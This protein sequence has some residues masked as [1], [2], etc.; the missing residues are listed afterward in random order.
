MLNVALSVEFKIRI[1]ERHHCSHSGIFLNFEQIQLK[2]LSLYRALIPSLIKD[3]SSIGVVMK[4]LLLKFCNIDRKRLVLE[5]FLIKL[6]GFWPAT[7]Y[8][9]RLQH[10]CFFQE[11]CEIITNTY[12]GQ[13]LWTAASKRSKL[14]HKRNS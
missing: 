7:L 10:R 12:L 9:K 11:Y 8:K 13:H 6:Q 2:I 1:P 4:K 14:Q 3:R 5:T